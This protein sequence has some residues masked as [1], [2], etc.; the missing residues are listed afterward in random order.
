[1]LQREIYAYGRT[2]TTPNLMDI[3]TGTSRRS[4]AK[5]S[6]CRWTVRKWVPT[7]TTSMATTDTS[8]DTTK[9]GLIQV[10]SIRALVLYSVRKTLISAASCDRPSYFSNYVGGTTFVRFLFGFGYA[11]LYI[12]HRT[13][14]NPNK[15]VLLCNKI[16]L[17]LDLV[18]LGK[19]RVYVYMHKWLCCC[20][21]RL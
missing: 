14:S 8:M 2:L 4:F 11:S 9:N 7:T 6:T 21:L 19:G 15:A 20:L 3:T 18:K 16:V 13:G 12:N 17:V 1:M 10:L 5:E